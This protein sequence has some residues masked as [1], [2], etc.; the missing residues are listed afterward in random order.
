[1]ARVQSRS[2]NRQSRIDPSRPKLPPLCVVTPSIVSGN[3]T[4]TAL[5][6]MQYKTPLPNDQN[7]ALPGLL[8]TN[9]GGGHLAGTVSLSN[10]GLTATI[11]LEG[12]TVAATGGTVTMS[13]FVQALTSIRGGILSIGSY[14]F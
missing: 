1:M 14:K 11:N 6:P 8:F 3:L 13:P 9:G 7:D 5:E 2:K 10:G 4:L 12:G